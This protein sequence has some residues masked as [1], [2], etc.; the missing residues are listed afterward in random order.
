MNTILVLFVCDSPLHHRKSISSDLRVPSTSWEVRALARWGGTAVSGMLLHIRLR[1]L[2]T[3][4]HTPEHVQR[5]VVVPT[6]EVK[7][8]GEATHMMEIIA[9]P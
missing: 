7:K 9:C 5:Y 3:V 2:V 4:P 8:L 6:P 1:S